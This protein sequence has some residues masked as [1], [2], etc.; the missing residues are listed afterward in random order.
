MTPVSDDKSKFNLLRPQWEITQIIEHIT[1]D[2][3]AFKLIE[4]YIEIKYF[5]II[6][7][8]DI[9]RNR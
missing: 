3:G 8:G 5:I 9:V 2:A 1:I 6:I 7:V 4:I